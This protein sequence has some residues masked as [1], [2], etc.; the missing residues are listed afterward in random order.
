MRFLI[1]LI[2]NVAVLALTLLVL[3]SAV[4]AG[5]IVFTAQQDDRRASD[6]IV[7]LGAA[8][9]NGRPG[10]YLEARLT[11]AKDLYDEGIAPVIV[12]TGGSLPGD[13]FSE[14]SA[15]ETWLEGQGVPA[16]SVLAIPQGTDTL[17]SMLATGQAMREHGWDSAVVV[18]DPWHSLRSTEMLHHAGID[19]VASPTRTGPSN[20][21]AWAAVK[22]TARETGAY[23]NWY[24]QRVTT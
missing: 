10:P 2:R 11:H 13:P 1:R 17:S 6:V 9:F 12:T 14:A 18:T 3:L 22:Y 21:G 16:R 23:L 15:G 4:T 19:A 5:R 20:A 7:V 24:R 8:Q